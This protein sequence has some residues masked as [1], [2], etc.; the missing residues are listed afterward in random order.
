MKLPAFLF[1][2]FLLL[3][4][5]SIASIDFKYQTYKCAVENYTKSQIFMNLSIAG[6]HKH[7]EKNSIQMFSDWGDIAFSY[8]PKGLTDKERR[9]IVEK[10]RS[11]LYNDLEKKY[12]DIV[13]NHSAILGSL[14]DC[15]M[16]EYLYSLKAPGYINFLE[17]KPIQ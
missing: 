16:R 8:T 13:N 15:G 4:S 2:N 10:D 7:L 14:R 3:S 6:K 9:R 12:G 1:L 5:F 17:G 11:N